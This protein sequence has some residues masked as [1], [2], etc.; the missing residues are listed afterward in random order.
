MAKLG[1]GDATV[2]VARSGIVVTG[3]ITSLLSYP[4]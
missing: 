4:C 3:Q 1:I 2:W